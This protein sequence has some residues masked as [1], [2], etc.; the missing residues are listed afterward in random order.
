MANWC[1]SE[2]C[3]DGDTRAVG[4]LYL[5]MRRLESMDKP[6]IENDFGVSWY[7]NLV[8][9]LGGDYR[10]MHCRGHWM[11]LQLVG[12]VLKWADMAAWGPVI[13]VFGLIERMWPGLRVYFSAEEE[14]NEVFLTND[15][16]GRHFTSRYILSTEQGWTYHDD[17]AS[18]L[19]DASAQYGKRIMTLDQLWDIIGLMD[20]WS[21]HEFEVM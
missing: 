9:R 12:S 21:L 2:V 18:L 1:F 14:S 17:E 5:M 7:G 6:L 16:T 10:S 3:V 13:D 4:E 19:N 15:T 8:Q 20:D 11:E